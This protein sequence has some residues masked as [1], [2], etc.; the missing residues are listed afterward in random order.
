MFL[1]I[2]CRF[3]LELKVYLK[4]SHKEVF[5]FSICLKQY[6]IDRTLKIPISTFHCLQV[7]F[8]RF[9]FSSTFLFVL[10]LF[11][12]TQRCSIKYFCTFTFIQGVK[13]Q[14]PMLPFFGVHGEFV[15][16]NLIYMVSVIKV[17][18]IQ[19]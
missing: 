7:L 6:S 19:R 11:S 3:I 2:L 10:L 9:A 4:R 1:Q 8:S 12:W 13:H 18:F 14:L 16:K 17:K 15:C 5:Y